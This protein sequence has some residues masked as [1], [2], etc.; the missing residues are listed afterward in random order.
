MILH[1]P[2]GLKVHGPWALAIGRRLLERYGID[3]KPTASDDG[4]VVRLPDTDLDSGDAPPGAELFVFEPEEIEPLVTAEVG[5]SALFASRFRECAARALLLPRRHPGKRSPLWHQRQRAAQLLDVAR[6]YPEFPIVLETVRECLQDVY[7]TTTLT[8]LM[9]RIA[10]RRV[11]LLEVQTPTPSPF[12]AS[13]LFCYVGA[14]MY[15]GDSPLAERRAAALSLDTTL[16][17]E[18][19]GR[20]EL[21]D[22]LDPEVVAA[23]A[24]Q[25]QHRTEGR[26]ARDAEGV[27]DLLRLLG[28]LTEAEIAERSTASDVGAWLEGLRTAKRALPVSYGGQTWWTAVED[29]GRLRDAVGVAVPVGVPSAFTESVAD[30]LGDLLARYARTNG[31]SA[32]HRLPPDSGWAC[33]WQPMSWAEW[34]WTPRWSV[35]NSPTPQTDPA[36]SGVTRKCCGSF[37]DGRW[38][39]CAPKSNPSALWAYARFSRPGNRSAVRELPPGSTGYSVPSSN[40]PGYRYPHPRSRA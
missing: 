15:E 20:V 32:P 25:L 35:A 12:A 26:R 7:D 33:G 21:R 5:G 23:T 9:A 10:Q 38:L 17:A 40:S 22:L 6:K 1:S 14:F 34:R 16:L 27:A 13:L 18:L 11:R 19:M 8:D 29:I 24:R 31:L 36:R 4:I 39:H 30:P 2:Y 28:P 37:A 3:E